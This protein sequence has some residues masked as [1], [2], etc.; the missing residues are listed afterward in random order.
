ME[1]SP[2]SGKN[3][4]TLSEDSEK[5][6]PRT[7][8]RKR[9]L[10]VIQEREK[11]S[12]NDPPQN[13]ENSEVPKMAIILENLEE[14][15]DA[16]T[17]TE[18][19]DHSGEKEISSEKFS[20]ELENNGGEISN[21]EKNS[22]R[23]N[24]K[25]SEENSSEGEAN[26]SENSETSKHLKNDDTGNLS[27]KSSENSDSEDS[28]PEPEPQP[29]VRRGRGRPPWRGRGRGRSRGRPPKR[30]RPS[31]RGVG[32]GTKRQTANSNT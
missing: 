1:I 21:S 26:S 27:D 16:E 4:E 13:L 10:K 15:V 20:P 23:K 24:Y 2:N 18:N 32:R 31:G 9:R 6:V 28:E 14:I 30:G 3:S 22:P 5:I 7:A 11:E 8:I 17:K 19:S 12:Q 29:E 25:K